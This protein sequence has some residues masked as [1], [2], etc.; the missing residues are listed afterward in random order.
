MEKRI[1]M[2]VSF[3]REFTS[4]C[5]ISTAHFCGVS[6]ALSVVVVVVV[7]GV[8]DGNDDNDDDATLYMVFFQ[9]QTL[10]YLQLTSKCVLEIKLINHIPSKV[11]KDLRMIKCLL[12]F[13]CP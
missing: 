10:V 3:H 13:L 11:L 8:V 2:F 1:Q 12:N 6:A 5:L 4:D 7:V 9:D